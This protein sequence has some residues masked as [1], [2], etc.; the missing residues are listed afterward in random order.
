[1]PKTGGTYTSSLTSVPDHINFSH[2]V[3]RDSRDDLACPV[4]LM[5]ISSAAV[6]GFF[7]W[8]NVR[9]PLRFLVSYYHW[10]KGF[11]PNSNT[12]HYD[13]APAQQGFDYF[14]K[15]I[16]SRDHSWPSR[17]FLFLNLF[18]HHAQCAVSWVNRMEQLDED[19]AK[20]SARFGIRYE[21]KSRQNVSPRE[22][23]DEDYYSEELLA[24]AS[25]TYSREMW[26]F[27]Y[28]GFDKTKPA[29]DLQP[30]ERSRIRYDYRTDELHVDKDIVPRTER[31]V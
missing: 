4:G 8:S 3:I 15:T 25:E 30:V 14:L 7:L 13:Y 11:G 17:R 31:H 28:D 26:L 16:T 12:T 6:E 19:M 20:I 18:D 23:R 24:L 22:T 27:G 21:P 2:V 29:V 5:P 9:N 10:A 1:M